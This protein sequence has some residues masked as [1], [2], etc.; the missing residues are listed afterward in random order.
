NVANLLLARGT[1]RRREIAIRTALGASRGR[2]VRQFLS[3]GL[4]L[5]A[6]GG[7]GGTVI[8]LWGVE[9]L[10]HIS[11][12]QIP[13]LHTVQIDRSVLAFTVLASMLTGI[14][15]GVLPA[16]QLSRSNPGDALKDGD[17]GGSGAHGTRTRQILVVA[18]VA[19]SLV[20]LTSAGLLL[21]SLMVLQRVSPGFVTEHAIVMQILLPQTRYPDAAAQIG[22]YHRLR[23]EVRAV[24]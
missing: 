1:V 20:L 3:E 10:V 23:D 5:A 12:V 2:I 4:V 7:A 24:P 15:C 17:R 22:F 21:R 8:A 18:E 9:A 13:R 16:F 14:L 19:L 6:L 11:P